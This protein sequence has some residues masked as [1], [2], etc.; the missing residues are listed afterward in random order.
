MSGLAYFPPGVSAQE[1]VSPAVN[2]SLSPTN[3]VCVI[4]LAQ[5]YELETQQ[6]TLTSGAGP[7]NVTVLVSGETIQQV[8]PT[9]AFVSVTNA[10]NP[11]IG[12]AP[13]QAGY[14]QGTDFTATLSSNGTYITVSGINGGALEQGG[15]INFTYQVIPQNYY[16]AMR[17]YS[18]A[19][20]EQ[21]YGPAFNAQGI[22]T[23]IS[24]GSYFAFE[25]GA[26]SVICQPL[27]VL[28][29]PSN[30]LSQPLQPTGAQ[31]A[32]STTWQ[33]TLY[34]VRSIPN[35]NFIVPI[36]GQSMPNIN[37][38]TQLSILETVQ[39]H[40]YYMETQENQY[41]QT[42][43][44]E[45]SSNNSTFA[46]DTTLQNH[47]QTLAARYGN[48]VTENIIFIAPSNF[49]R[50]LPTQRNVTLYAGG[51]YV[52]A[53]LAGQIA[54]STVNTGFTHTIVPNWTNVPTYRDRATKNA[55]AQAGLLVIENNINNPGTIIVRHA[56][57]ANNTTVD[58][59]A[60]NVVRAKFLMISSLINA[61]NTQL[62]GKIP[63]D[64]N[65]PT[66]IAM[67]TTQTLQSLVNTGAIVDFTGVQASLVPADPT[68]GQVAFSWLPAFPLDYIDILFSLNLTN[69]S[70]P[71][72]VAT[73]VQS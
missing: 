62:I 41:I 45:D 28:S 66:L 3:N 70:V 18:Q 73:G 1:Q 2:S 20:V 9:Q 5:G 59:R 34:A 22:Q 21:T 43:L 71:I 44:G 38:A 54:N 48:A 40:I 36:V 16:T 37:D 39:D 69:G 15:T 7:F 35:L 58:R 23:P 55:D 56:I 72:S 65:A 27:F 29:N 47:I 11:T 4:G 42:A 32:Q 60:L 51:E 19:A 67:L 30:P 68:T 17:F 64:G 8:S 24:A 46:T 52:A 57:T 26:Q 53:T 31:P 14:L 25:G 33:Q 61:F 13:N 50:P 49:Q 12:A 6:I 63:A 10:I